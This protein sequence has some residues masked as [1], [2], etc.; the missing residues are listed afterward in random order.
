VAYDAGESAIIVPVPAVEPLVSQWRQRFDVSAR[1]GVPAHITV[2]YPFPALEPARRRRA[3]PA[4]C[5]LRDGIGA[6]G[7]AWVEAA[8]LYAYDG[9]R[10]RPR[11]V[12]PF[13]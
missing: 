9:E 6:G 1:H 11:A 2:L 5:R 10:W 3:G 7:R 13:G 8:W 4:A 12:L